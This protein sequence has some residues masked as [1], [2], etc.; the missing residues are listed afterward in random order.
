MGWIFMISTLAL[1]STITPVASFLLSEISFLSLIF[2]KDLYFTCFMTLKKLRSAFSLLNSGSPCPSHHRVP[3]NC[4]FSVVP[5]S[6]QPLSLWDESQ[7]LVSV[8]SEL[9]NTGH[10]S[11]EPSHHA[12]PSLLLALASSRNPP[13]TWGQG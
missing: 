9:H 6:L 3:L 2:S 7:E 8:L 4:E 1:I 13:M 11:Q 10:V 12:S 5:N